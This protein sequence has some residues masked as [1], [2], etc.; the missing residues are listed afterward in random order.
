M[1]YLVKPLSPCCTPLFSVLAAPPITAYDLWVERTRRSAS[2]ISLFHNVH[3]LFLVETPAVIMAALA[4]GK[5]LMPERSM[6]L[7]SD[8][9]VGGWR[10]CS[11]A[12]GETE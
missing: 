1:A 9:V 3:T 12:D 4:I 6:S 2:A 11:E 8:V 5:L 10:L 7:L